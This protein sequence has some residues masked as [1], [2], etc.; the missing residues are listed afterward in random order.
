MTRC[1]YMT[2]VAKAGLLDALQGFDP[3]LA[4][5]PPLG[6]D[7]ESSDIDVLCH[8]PSE[9]SFAATVWSSFSDL[10]D[11]RMRQWSGTNRPIIASFFAYD[12]QFEI[13]AAPEPVHQ[14]A[15]WRHFQVEA[16]FLDLAS[17]A[18]REAIMELRGRGVKTEPA[19][20]SALGLR[21]DP[22]Q[23]LLDLYPETDDQ[24]CHSLQAAG[25]STR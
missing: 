13:F 19:F 25:F 16:R 8:A 18:F 2:A 10:P 11:F 22:Y 7:V 23:L 12:W 24:L 6:L 4:G 5:T 14:Q 20:A 15:G 9:G 21:G 3:H 1:D 17:S